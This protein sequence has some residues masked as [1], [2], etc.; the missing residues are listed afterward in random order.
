MWEQKSHTSVV[1]VPEPQD[2]LKAILSCLISEV[3]E[4]T[5]CQTKPLSIVLN[6]LLVRPY[7]CRAN[8]KP[9]KVIKH[10]DLSYIQ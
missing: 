3:A 4:G 2:L 1:S 5:N 8:Q 6:A 9:F 10:H 7:C